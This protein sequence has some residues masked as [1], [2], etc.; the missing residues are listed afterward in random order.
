M[1]WDLY[2]IG[3]FHIPIMCLNCTQRFRNQKN[4]PGLEPVLSHLDWLHKICQEQEDVSCKFDFSF[5]EFV[6]MT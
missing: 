5:Y 3:R 6:A 2:S 4:Q 1:N